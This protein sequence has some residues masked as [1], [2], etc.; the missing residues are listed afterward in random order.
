MFNT[1]YACS[2]S[3]TG[4]PTRNHLIKPLP[5]IL[6]LFNLKN[7]FICLTLLNL[8]FSSQNIFELKENKKTKQKMNKTKQTQQ[9]STPLCFFCKTLLSSK[10][11]ACFSVDN[12]LH[13]YIHFSLKPALCSLF[14]EKLLGV[15]ICLLNL[16]CV[17]ANMTWQPSTSRLIAQP[18]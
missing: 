1:L 17:G 10:L 3:V 16:L 11:F 5:Y 15:Y 9:Q 14:S 4:T 7:F 2:P 12:H 8:G 13:A 6:G 18:L